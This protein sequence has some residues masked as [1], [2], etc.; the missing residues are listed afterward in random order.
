M[1]KL[2]GEIFSHMGHLPQCGHGRYALPHALPEPQLL[3]ISN[4]RTAPLG[5]VGALNEII[6]HVQH[7]ARHQV[8][9]QPGQL[10]QGTWPTLHT[11]ET[12]AS[13]D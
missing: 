9:T 7:S 5:W 6:T 4:V 2:L 8:G 13:A 10:L 3:S 1:E 12:L 11:E